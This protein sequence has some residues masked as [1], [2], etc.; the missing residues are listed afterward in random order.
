MFR[1]ITAEEAAR[2]GR[3]A[4]FVWVNGKIVWRTNA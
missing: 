3:F 1:T 2:L 4:W